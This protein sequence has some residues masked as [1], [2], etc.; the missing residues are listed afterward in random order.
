MEQPAS[1]QERS[2]DEIKQAQQRLRPYGYSGPID[3]D[4]GPE[5]TDAVRRFQESANLGA[6][7]R[8]DD[9]TWAA[10][11]TQPPSAGRPRLHLVADQPQ[12]PDHDLLGFEA[13]AR[14]LAGVIDNP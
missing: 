1:P 7:G 6:T 9:A 11:S 14:A 2:P 12:I 4:L 13:Y 10:L 5:T 8:L 3:G